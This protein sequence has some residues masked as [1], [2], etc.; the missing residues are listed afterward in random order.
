MDECGQTGMCDNGKC[1]NM[2]GSFKC[3]C[4]SGY[5]LSSDGKTCIGKNKRS[6]CILIVGNLKNEKCVHLDIDECN[7][8]PCQNG[9]CINSAGSF[10]CECPPGLVLG[11][12]GRSCLDSRRDVC[13]AHFRDGQ[14]LNPSTSLVTKSSCCCCTVILGQ[15]MGWGTPCQACPQP[16]SEEFEQLCPF[17]SGKTHSGDGTKI[18]VNS[19]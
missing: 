7:Q 9:I 15:P 18:Y 14:C 6:N 17:G 8:N 12:D 3:V 2:D 5:K 4:D 1:I 13:Y 16:D 19:N 10:K 11:I